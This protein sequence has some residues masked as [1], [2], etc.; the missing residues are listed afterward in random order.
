MQN[1]YIETC[2]PVAEVRS[3]VVSETV[4]G[5]IETIHAIGPEFADRAAYYDENDAFVVENYQVLKAHKLF[6]AGIPTELGGGG[7]NHR[8]LC[9]AIRTL[10]GYC[11]STALALSMHSHVVGTAVF[12]H[13][14]GK[15]GKKLLELVA[16]RE[17]V[18]VSTGGN[19]WLDSSGTMDKVDGGYRV[20]AHKPFASGSPA[21]DFLVTSARYKDP[22]KGWTVLHFPI[23]TR[24]PGVDIEDNWKTLGMRGTGSNTIVL[25]DAFV[26]DEAVTLRR[27]IGEF[28]AVWNVIVPIATPIIMAAYV[29][30][31]EAAAGIARKTA[32]K[33]TGGETLPYLLG[34]M[35]N[36]LTVAQIALESMQDITD[37]YRFTPSLENTNAILIRKTLVE[38]AVI[39]TAEKAVA[40]VGGAA[41]FRDQGLE[42]LLRDVHASVFHPLPEKEQHRFTGR[43]VLGLDP[44]GISTD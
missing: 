28:H 36:A 18:M 38:N 25:E 33:R 31:A 43:F 12:S 14:R 23:S 8:E 32:R 19:D 2:K 27:P 9:T 10:A 40:A 7:L 3:P 35:E 11:G 26:P 21:G 24:A 41:Y 17:A 34:E 44:V 20:N 22:E 16:G 1:R 39:E 5:M 4:S 42:R 15:P 6:S 29:G 13:A 37:N 30:V